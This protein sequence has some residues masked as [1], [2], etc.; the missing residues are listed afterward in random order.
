MNWYY[1]SLRMAFTDWTA[2]IHDKASND[3][4]RW[5]E[6]SKTTLI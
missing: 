6:S 3:S 2:E 1:D 4:Q 5:S